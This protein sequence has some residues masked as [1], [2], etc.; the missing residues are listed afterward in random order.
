M[1]AGMRYLV[2]APGA[3]LSG[4][5]LLHLS[6]RSASVLIP[7]LRAA[8]LALMA[9]GALTLF[10]SA[11]DPRLAWLP[12]TADFIGFAGLPVQLFRAV[13]AVLL[14]VAFV[15]IIRHA[16]NQAVGTLI[17][18]A[19]LRESEEKYRTLFEMSQ[20]A[21]VTLDE[22]GFVDCNQAALRMFGFQEKAEFLGKFPNDL[23][24]PS[25]ADGRDSASAADQQ[26]KK[27][28]QEGRNLF[29]WT[30]MRRNGETFPAEVLLTP[31]TLLGRAVIQAIVRDISE[32]KHMEAALQQERDFASSIVDT[33]PV[34]ILL[35]DTR[36][37]IQHVNP[38]F[39]QLT[40]YRLD[41]IKGKEWFSAFLP[42]RDQERIRALFNNAAGGV[43]TRGHINPIVLRS[44]EEREIEWHD[45]VLRD[46]GG[47]I[48]GLLAIGQDVTERGK[49]Q[50]ALVRREQEL[51]QFKNTL[52]RTLDCVF[53]FDA[54]SLVFFY[55]N[56]GGLQ[57]VGYTHEE[58]MAMHPYDIKP[59]ITEA[60]F[61]RRIAPLLAG[62]KASLT[63]ET[64]HQHKNGRRLPVEIFLQYIA[65]TSEPAR[66]VAIVRDIGERKRAE[67][68][69]RNINQALEQ[70]VEQRTADMKAA[71]DEAE[72]ANMAKSE[73]LSR[74]SHELRTPLNAI[75]GFGQLLETDPEHPLAEIQADN[76]QEILHAG[77][78]LLELVNEVLDLSRIEGGRLDVKLEPVNIGPLIVSCVKQ[79]QPS[80][81]QRSI[82]IELDMNASY[83]VQADR[84]RL[85][86]V[87]LNLL[88][89]AVKYNREGGHI[90]LSCA[91]TGAHRL[92]IRVRDTGR[93]IAAAA[94]PRLFRPFERLESAYNGI[95]GTGIGL[96][97]AKKLVEAMHG[98]IGAES[99]QGEGS[100][101][102]FELPLAIPAEKNSAP[103]AS[104]FGRHRLLYIEDNP[105]N[106]RLVN[107]I[108]ATRKDIELLEAASAEAGLEIVKN[109]QPDLIL[110]D[111][112][113]PGMDG[114][115][116]LR[117]LRDDPA[118]RDIPLIAVSANAMPRDI[119]R[120]KAAGFNDY[121]V[122]P[123][124]IGQFLKAVDRCLAGCME[125]ET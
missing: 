103:A 44:G 63:F 88:S 100:T 14:A 39:E 80:A 109:Q 118:T 99:T 30:Y 21:L 37:S 24:P 85:K 119:A 69:L 111:V 96:A 98:E 23:S 70:R 40:G 83:A 41:E 18:D 75:I 26:V 82:R 51:N 58:L 107:K 35:L 123:L 19:V 91:L 12:T 79:L 124:D 45:Q 121:L 101:F 11:G 22:S 112:N 36:G 77:N 65:P 8:A 38:C 4:F 76:V 2:G 25:Q 29:E 117:Q 81:A 46:P 93:G 89:N 68:A 56:Q 125:N 53:M 55:V 122:K 62:E 78:H 7:W 105:A 49:T 59:D 1:A 48:K 6:T 5:A 72:R 104:R 94:L 16:N 110:L 28:Y 114:Y 87:L 43:S 47:S 92:R 90:Q 3:L 86:E 97:L 73:F 57:Q 108:I 116:A 67:A 102:W 60:Q 115:E 52:D 74:M 71:K 54:R 13:C 10:L 31:M 17:R 27:A 64:V 66:F 34:I 33:A 20:D 32:R 9:Y 84:T 113:L 15:V 42:V 95:E 120:G 50:L 61:R 106:M